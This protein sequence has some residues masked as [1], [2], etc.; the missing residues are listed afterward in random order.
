VFVVTGGLAVAGAVAAF[1]LMR[2]ERKAGPAASS[3]GPSGPNHK[4]PAI[5]HT[6]ID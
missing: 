1:V 3:P 4:E 5:G 6:T 2:R